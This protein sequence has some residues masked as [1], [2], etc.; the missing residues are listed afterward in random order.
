LTKRTTITPKR[1]AEVF[2]DAG[3]ICHLCSRKIAPGEPWD[4]EHP[5]AIGLGGADDKTN[6]LPAHKDCH[7]GKSREDIRIMRKADRQMKK[8]IGVKTSRNPLPGGKRSK[9]KKRMDGTVVER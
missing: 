2:R 8:A 5:K 9:W 1:R 3:G 6:W 4:V 7:A